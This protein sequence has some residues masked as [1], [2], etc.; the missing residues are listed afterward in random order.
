MAPSLR[1]L[2]ISDVF[3]SIVADG[4]ETFNDLLDLAIFRCN[5]DIP[6]DEI[7]LT[8][9][10]YVTEKQVERLKE[11]VVDVECDDCQRWGIQDI[12]RDEDFG[13][14]DYEADFRYDNSD[15]EW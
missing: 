2:R 10:H 4:L 15:D 8:E 7:H 14:Y 1:V 9:C 11:V 12:D 13:Y 3:F 6:I 5:Y